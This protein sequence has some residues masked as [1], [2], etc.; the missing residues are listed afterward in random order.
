MHRKQKTAFRSATTKQQPPSNRHVTQLE[1]GK[2]K[3][4]QRI[5]QQN[6]NKRLAATTTTKTG[7]IQLSDDGNSIVTHEWAGAEGSRHNTTRNVQP[8]RLKQQHHFAGIPRQQQQEKFQESS[9]GTT[10]TLGDQT[11]HSPVSPPP[12]DTHTYPSDQLAQ[13]PNTHTLLAARH[14]SA[15][16]TPGQECAAK[17]T[18]NKKQTTTIATTNNN[19]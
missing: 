7:C 17:T 1:G 6:N 18:N 4:G 13:P 3:E 16:C 15:S 5:Y 2:E 9:S 14:C 8:V 11:T 10:F 12:L 19:Q